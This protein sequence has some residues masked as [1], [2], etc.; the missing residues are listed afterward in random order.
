MEG[1]PSLPGLSAKTCVRLRGVGKGTR[2]R[3]GALAAG[4]AEEEVQIQKIGCRL[5]RS[6]WIQLLVSVVVAM[7]EMA[8]ATR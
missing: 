5:L 3:G 4:G 1:Q 8:R 2:G 6:G 7:S